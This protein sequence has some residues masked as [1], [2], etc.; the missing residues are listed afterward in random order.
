MF[1][2]LYILYYIFGYMDNKSRYC[3]K[4]VSKYTNYVESISD[5]FNIHEFHLYCHS[6]SILTLKSVKESEKNKRKIISI[7]NYSKIYKKNEKYKIEIVPYNYELKYDTKIF[8][9]SNYDYYHLFF[10]L[11]DIKNISQIIKECN[12]N[13]NVIL[14]LEKNK[15]WE[16][17]LNN[18]IFR[19]RL[20]IIYCDY[21]NN[22]NPKSYCDYY[23]NSCGYFSIG[24]LSNLNGIFN[25][26]ILKLEL[27]VSFGCKCDICK[28]SCDEKKKFY[29]LNT[30]NKYIYEYI[31]KYGYNIKSQSDDC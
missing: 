5:D 29:H 22:I 2:I 31:N 26:L 27:L 20:G 15:F 19:C 8:G 17:N 4:F 12:V 28:S 23:Y 16:S 7:I 30:D 6:T 1:V 14:N 9:R 25:S 21:Y 18:G 11:R 10:I 3:F 24:N 13:C